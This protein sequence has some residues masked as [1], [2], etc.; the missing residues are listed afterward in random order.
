MQHMIDVIWKI[1][2]L[3]AE[4]FRKSKNKYEQIVA[5][6]GKQVTTLRGMR[7]VVRNQ[8]PQRKTITR[9]L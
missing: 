3:P 7:A 1:E 6:K 8:A 2:H 4:R 5:E 9:I